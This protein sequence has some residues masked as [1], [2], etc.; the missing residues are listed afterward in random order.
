MGGCEIPGATSPALVTNYKP[1]D[2]SNQLPVHPALLLMGE[3]REILWRR[4]RK[5]RTRK[6]TLLFPAPGQGFG[7]TQSVGNN[8]NFRFLFCPSSQARLGFAL[9][10]GIFFSFFFKEM[11]LRHKDSQDN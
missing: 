2:C 4:G 9:G 3:K 1:A 11:G 6:R 8:K 10:K 5:E 7:W